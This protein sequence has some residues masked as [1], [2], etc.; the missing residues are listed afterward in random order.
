M[1]SKKL[2]FEIPRV[3][4]EGFYEFNK[5]EGE[6]YAI[7][8]HIKYTRINTQNIYTSTWYPFQVSL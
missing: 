1:C 5:N 3:L 6:V 7:Y 2:I 8:L 4:T